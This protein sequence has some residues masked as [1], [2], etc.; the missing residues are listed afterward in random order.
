MIHHIGI[1]TTKTALEGNI[2][3]ALLTNTGANVCC[4]EFP[5]CSTVY[6]LDA[7]SCIIAFKRVPSVTSVG[8][9]LFVRSRW[10]SGSSHVLLF[11]RNILTGDCCQKQSEINIK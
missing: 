8:H 7:F 11:G 9:Q 10:A 4:V 5:I 1:S 2:F 6:G 3:T